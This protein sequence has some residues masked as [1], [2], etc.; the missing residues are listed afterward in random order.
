MLDREDKPMPDPSLRI[1]LF[2]SLA[3]LAGGCFVLPATRTTTR[4]IGTT[5]GAMTEGPIREIAVT[6]ETTASAVVIR[7][8]AERTCQR[9]VLEV[10]ELWTTKHARLGGARDPRATVFGAVLAP[11]TIPLSSLVT[12]AIVLADDGHLTRT[13][14]VVDTKTFPC[15]TV[16]RSVQVHVKFPSGASNDGVTDANGRLAFRIPETEP[17]RGVVI[18]RTGAAEPTVVAYERPKPA[19]TAARD[20]VTSCATRHELAGAVTLRLTTNLRGHPTRVG[21]DRGSSEFVACVGTGLSS[22]RFP[23]AQRATTLV[24][25]LELPAPGPR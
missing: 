13:T 4:R 17:Y 16:A 5:E 2:A 6:T 19:V 9:P 3:V 25:A 8:T 22:L 11:I 10:T 21:L 12:G 23:A 24:L 1:V 15:T 18:T 20:V 14:R 7:A